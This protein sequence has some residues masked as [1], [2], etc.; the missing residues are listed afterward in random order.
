MAA[1]ELLKKEEQ[2]AKRQRLEEC[3]KR[4]QALREKLAALN[5]SGVASSTDAAPPAAPAPASAP[6]S[7]PDDATTEVLSQCSQPRLPS[8]GNPS[9]AGLN[10]PEL[11]RA[12]P[13]EVSP[14]HGSADSGFL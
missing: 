14:S 12:T 6:A 10:V 7:V 8:E 3:Q 5:T 13:L 11:R 2:A 9:P 4:T 1:E